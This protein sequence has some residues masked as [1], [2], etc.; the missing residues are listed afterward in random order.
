MFRPFLLMAVG[1]A[2]GGW[3]AAI[4]GYEVA[5]SSTPFHFRVGFFRLAD[6][7]EATREREEE[8]GK[9]RRGERIV[10]YRIKR[11]LNYT[12]KIISL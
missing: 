5:L 3:A 8:K 10:F 12:I 1:S 7:E 4:F 2:L 6:T 11:G 9:R